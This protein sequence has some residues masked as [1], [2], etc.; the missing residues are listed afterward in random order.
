MES[1]ILIIAT[2]TI[3]KIKKINKLKKGLDNFQKT[4]VIKI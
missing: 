4:C 1:L 3:I 2:I